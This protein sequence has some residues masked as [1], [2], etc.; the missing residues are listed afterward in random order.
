MEV[1]CLGEMGSLTANLTQIK[2]AI[3]AAAPEDELLLLPPSTDDAILSLST[4]KERDSKNRE[5]TGQ[6]SS[7]TVT[8][9]WQS[10]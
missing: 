8:R 9:G 2:I 7:S 4:R 10:A 6:L 3:D 5:I 1:K